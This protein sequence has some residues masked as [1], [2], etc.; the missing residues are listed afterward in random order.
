MSYLPQIKPARL[1]PILIKLGFKIIRQ[2]GS[3]ITL[4][5]ILDKTRKVTIA[6]HNIDLPK[7]TLLSIIKQAKLSV[8]EFLKFIGR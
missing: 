7:K 8:S 6:M 1:V 3:H 5:H 2:K 4:E